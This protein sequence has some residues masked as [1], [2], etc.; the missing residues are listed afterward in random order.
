MKQITLGIF[1]AVSLTSNVWA[2]GHPSGQAQQPA[3]SPMP[4]PSHAESSPATAAASSMSKAQVASLQSLLKQVYLDAARARDLL[5]LIEPSQLKMTD[6]ER[7]AVGQQITTLRGQLDTLEKWRYAWFYNPAN[8]ADAQKTLDALSAAVGQLRA[9]Q[10]ASPEEASLRAPADGLYEL[11]GRLQTELAAL[12]PGQFASNPPSA[13]ASA[14]AAAPPARRAAPTA[15]TSSKPQPGAVAPPGRTSPASKATAA[16]LAAPLDPKQVKVLLSK[17][18]LAAARV[19]DLDGLIQPDKWK[20]NDADRALLQEKL[21][22]LRSQMNGLEQA[23]YQLFYHPEDPALAAHV[24]SRLSAVVPAIRVIAAL[25]GQYGNARDAAE[26]SQPAGE[27]ATAEVDL[28]AYAAY[29]HQ[30]I[31]QQLAARPADLPGGVALETERIAAP[32]AGAA[33][34][35]SVTIFTPPMTPA[36]VKAILYEIYVSEF[37]IHDLLGQEHPEQWKVPQ[38]EQALVSQARA[39]LLSQL[40][41]LETWRARLAQEPE[42]MY[43]AFEVFRAV[44]EVFHPLRVFGREVTRYQG[45]SLGEPYLRRSDDLETSINGLMPYVGAILQHD[46]DNAAMMQVGLDTC[47]NQLTYAMRGTLHAPAP[48]RNVVPVFQGRRARSRKQ[49]AKDNSPAVKK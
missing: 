1:L 45:A 23:R 48:L 30:R 38:A 21:N 33:P 18:Y 4:A 9:I 47:E 20:M 41:T 27:L 11:R 35:K 37:R 16:T 7:A 34:L 25:A 36:Q 40:A 22:A 24:S 32:T 19:N 28:A 46:S 13:A 31:E 2:A 8:S 10:N 17:V 14:P 5:G 26:L 29:L 12:F 49:P 3:G 39:T 42:N 15:S 6:A 43:Y 44:D